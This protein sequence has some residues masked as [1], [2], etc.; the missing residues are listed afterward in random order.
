MQ[1]TEKKNSHGLFFL[2]VFLFP[3]IKRAKEVSGFF[4]SKGR[5]KM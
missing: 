1:K 5:S 4:S 3:V 2:T